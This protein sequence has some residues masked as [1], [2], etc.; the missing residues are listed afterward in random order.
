M[1]IRRD[2][3]TVFWRSPAGLT[4]GVFL[5]VGALFLVLEHG[6]HLLGAWPLLFLL[7][8]GGMHFFMHRG[9]GGHRSHGGHDRRGSDGGPGDER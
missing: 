4:L 7:L 6:A 3:R 9:H 1:N 8:C 2:D 5:A